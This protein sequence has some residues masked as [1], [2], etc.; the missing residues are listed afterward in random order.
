MKIKKELYVKLPEVDAE[1]EAIIDFGRG[2]SLPDT[3][4]LMQ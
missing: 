2:L 4:E 3:R 1:L